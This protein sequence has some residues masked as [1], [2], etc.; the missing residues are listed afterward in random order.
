MTTIIRQ[1][2]GSLKTRLLKKVNDIP[3][4]LDDERK[5]VE[6]HDAAKFDTF[7]RYISEL[8]FAVK[9]DDSK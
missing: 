1:K 7:H 2:L 6:T 9:N 8:E 4:L 3:K 5:A